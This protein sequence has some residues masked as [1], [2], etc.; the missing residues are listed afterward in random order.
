MWDSLNK[1]TNKYKGTTETQR[2][3]P[4]L[5][6]QEEGSFSQGINSVNTEPHTMRTAPKTLSVLSWMAHDDEA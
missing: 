2:L 5:H 1:Q 6:C 4:Q 3:C